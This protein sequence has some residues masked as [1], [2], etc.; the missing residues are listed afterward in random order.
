MTANSHISLAKYLDAKKRLVER[1][2][3]DY[4]ENNNPAVENIF[5]AARY[6]LLA[7][8]KRLRPILCIAAWDALGGDSSYEDVLPAACA[9][10]MIHTYS[11]IH[12]DLPAMDNDDLRRGVATNH[13]VFG[14]GMAVLAGDALLTESFALLSSPAVMRGIDASRRL[15]V[16]SLIASSAGMNGMI[17]GQVIDMKAEGQT[18]NLSDL[19]R[20]HMLKTGVLIEASLEAGGILAG[21]DKKAIRALT[22]YGRGI[23][24]SFQIIDDLLNVEGD[25]AILGKSTGSDVR[26]RKVTYPSLIGCEASRELADRITAKAL[27]ALSGFDDRAE[28]LRKIASYITTRKY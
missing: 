24:L 5:E 22:D 3:K 14:E 28:P 11:L 8:G 21:G 27:A 16:I 20:L 9:I 25:K 12:D 6:S 18:M 26:R 1:A 19:Q 7:G 23:G 13:R 15:E 10:E 4:L 2:L 17:A